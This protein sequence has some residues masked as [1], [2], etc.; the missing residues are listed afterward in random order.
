MV[1]KMFYII[2]YIT[3]ATGVE[4]AAN[5]ASKGW[6]HDYGGA[7]HAIAVTGRTYH[8]MPTTKPGVGP[9][10]GLSYFVYD[11]RAAL[12]GHA[13]SRNTSQTSKYDHISQEIVHDIFEDMLEYNPI[14]E[15]IHGF[16]TDE[17]LQHLLHGN[18]GYQAGIATVS[19]H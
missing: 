6:C 19:S 10:G 17:H 18:E 11:S 7:P 14:C 12:A 2:V 8:F 5:S 1:Y 15:T 4:K 3:G 13:A 16:G 9:S